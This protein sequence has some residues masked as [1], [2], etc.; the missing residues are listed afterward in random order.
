M[1]KRAWCNECNS[2]VELAEGD[3]CP[4]GH[5]QSALQGI[6]ELASAVTS[7]AHAGAPLGVPTAPSFGP[8]P[9]PASSAASREWSLESLPATPTR[10]PSWPKWLAL[11][12]AA[13][14]IGGGIAW[15]RRPL[16]GTIHTQMG[17]WVTL[18]KGWHMVGQRPYQFIASPDE[19]ADVA[20]EFDLTTDPKKLV[21]NDLVRLDAMVF[22][23]VHSGASPDSVRWM[24]ATGIVFEERSGAHVMKRT[25]AWDGKYATYRADY[26]ADD[27][28]YA[29][30]LADADNIVTSIHWPAK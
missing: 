16:T 9:S 7:E 6:E 18:P 3:V 23:R 11:L 13:L 19:H 10:P 27:P 21:T 17:V 2:F 25:E 30:Y 29:Q 1:P 15:I 20:V 14:A 4:W 26:D 5:S 8:P 28:L 24:G 22:Q 12:L